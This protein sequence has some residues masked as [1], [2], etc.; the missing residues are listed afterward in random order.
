MSERRFTWGDTVRVAE[1]Q[2]LHLAWRP[3]SLGAICGL[4]KI[5]TERQASSSS[6]EL[7]TILYTVEFEDGESVEI[8]GDLLEPVVEA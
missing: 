2:G 3:G 7:G 4:R 5:E 6:L 1:K 8:P